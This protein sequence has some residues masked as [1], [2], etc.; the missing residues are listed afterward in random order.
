[1]NEFV[2]HV[3]YVYIDSWEYVK[4]RLMCYVRVI[5]EDFVL[6]GQSIRKWII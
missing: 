4:P 6:W 3:F 1:M 2:M 5:I